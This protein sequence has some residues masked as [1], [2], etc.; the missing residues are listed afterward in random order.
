[1]NYL[2]VSFK[3]EPIE[4]WGDLLADELISVGFETFEQTP[5]GVE[6]YIDETE[7]DEA[8]L[9]ALS[10]LNDERLSF[11]YQVKK[12]V[13]QNWNE[14]WEKNFDPIEV[15]EKC[16]VRASF[17]SK[18]AVEFDLLIDPKMA[19][20]TGHH[21]TTFLMLNAMF[22]LDFK[23]TKVLDMGTGTGVLGIL[24]ARKGAD[25]VLGVDNNVWACESAVENVKVNG[26]EVMEIKEG[27]VEQVSGTFD[28]IIANI[29]RNIVM[30]QIPLYASWLN[31]GGILLTSGFFVQDASQLKTVAKNAGLSYMK[32]DEK[33]NWAMV[34]FKK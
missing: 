27:E 13:A 17:H 18:P 3:L 8:K 10:I 25:Y 9:K 15:N 16:V 2:Q 23:N 31:P 14:E 26:A 21:Q 11:S 33:E 34:Q 29:N 5:S 28:V 19:F 7:F 4:P 1:M 6:A 12:H 22:E 30:D 24:A 32:T 20:G